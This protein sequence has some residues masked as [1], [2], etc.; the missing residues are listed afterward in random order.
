MQR[1]L[2]GRVDGGPQEGVEVD[3]EDDDDRGA[4]GR[5]KIE[6]GEMRLKITN[7]A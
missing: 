6:S 7:L 2:A 3:L 1:P 5:F 4:T